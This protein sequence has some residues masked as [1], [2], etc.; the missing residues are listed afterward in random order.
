[1]LGSKETR[2]QGHAIKCDDDGE[3]NHSRIVASAGR[4]DRAYSRSEEHDGRSV[5]TFMPCEEALTANMPKMKRK[6][7]GG[8][9]GARA[10]NK[11]EESMLALLAQAGSSSAP[12]MN[13]RYAARGFNQLEEEDDGPQTQTCK[14]LC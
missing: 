2:E 1:M 9:S 6:K 7:K 10:Y 8:S 11:R 12:S 3:G 14:S 4:K 5:A 13:K